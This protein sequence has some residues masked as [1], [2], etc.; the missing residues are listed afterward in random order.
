MLFKALPFSIAAACALITLTA[1]A[2]EDPFLWLEEINSS[3]SLDWVNQ[4]NAI[5]LGRMENR[6][7]FP[8]LEKEL[9][10]III[11]NQRL[12]AISLHNGQIYTFWQDQAHPRGLWQRTSLESYQ[13]PAPV[14]EVLLDLDKLN[15][16]EGKTW[17][18]KGANCLEPAHVSCLISLS[19][20]GGDAVE[21][22]EF[23]IDQKFFVSGGFQLAVA[24][25][26]ASWVDQNTLIVG[27]DFGP[28]SLSKAGYP[29]ILKR[30]KRGT[31]LTE[32]Q[33]IF[34]GQ[35][36]DI[37]VT[38]DIS[39]QPGWQPE[40]WIRNL[41][42]FESEVNLVLPDGKLARIP[43]PTD[44]VLETTIGAKAFFTL[45]TPLKTKSRLFI[46]GSLVA[47]PLLK[48]EQGE[49]SLESL[50][51]VFA[52]SEK[53]FL[54]GVIRSGNSLLLNVLDNVRGKLLRTQRAGPGWRSKEIA[55]GE[56]GQA[57]A[58]A[59]D[60]F[61]DA[62]LATYT[63][64]LTPTTQFLGNSASVK[65]KALRSS[66]A[67]FDGSS[68]ITEQHEAFSKDGTK[69]PYFLI[70]PKGMLL[71]GTHPTLLY[72][73]G[74]FA[75]P[76]S[77]QYS[78]TLGKAWLEKGGVY[79]LANIRGG[80]E[81]GPAWHEAA[82]KKNRQ[83]AYDDFIAVAEDLIAKK[84]TT[85]AHLGIEGGSNG[86]LLVGA[87]FVQRPELFSAVLCKVPLLDMMR[88]HLLL[89][90]SSW[91]GE[92]G[93]PDDPD[94]REA[95]LKYSPYQ[96][97][98][99]EGQYPEVFFTTSTRD[100]RVHPAHARKMA[101]LMESQGHSVFYFENTEGGHGGSATPEQQARMLAMEYSYLWSKLSP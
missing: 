84:I 83:R 54:S 11:N 29:L 71:D 3:R 99:A 38:S 52:P 89:A 75:V 101:A 91:V 66:P 48:T 41:S 56:N 69:V 32:A 20:G 26:H 57:E 50:E 39:I 10:A 70:H 59:G 68:D 34:R 30:W 31:P 2:A 80:G 42:F 22:R 86:G 88:Y 94:M 67:F 18:W 73:Y 49:A 37:S 51:L 13:R 82:L 87:T 61:S 60:A 5:T 28:G 45:R 79:V 97:V 24:K 14:W 81:F 85:P 17:V 76:M 77:P 93:N 90:G 72:G 25:T 95:I 74:G 100:D 63:D 92:Y 47:Y 1:Q 43:L 62:F 6:A 9:K 44:A 65:V 98:K 12:P 55:M 53:R 7:I 35:P 23:R 78:G 33:E 36:S 64:F 8:A 4:H 15:Q 21:I 58:S 40:F 19:P 96:N 27:T 46:T 16:T